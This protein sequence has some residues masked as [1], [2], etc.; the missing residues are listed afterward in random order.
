ME[1]DTGHLSYNKVYFPKSHATLGLPMTQTASQASEPAHHL[2]D[3]LAH[4]IATLLAPMFLL[5]TGGDIALAHLAALETL[6]SYR[7]RNH[8]D[9]IAV[10]QIVG[11]GLAALGSVSR[12]MEDDLSVSMVLRL[13]GNAVALNRTVEHARRALGTNRPEPPPAIEPVDL[14]TEAAVLSSVADTQQRVR[15]AK[16]HLRTPDPVPPSEPGN[17]ALT[18]QQRQAA[19]ASAMSDVANEFT[20]GLSNL[21]PVERKLASLRAAALSS[22][23][24]QLLS[25]EVP[26]RP[27]PGDLA[28]LMRP[29]RG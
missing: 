21:P 1:K 12:S 11:C 2:A 3:V 6:N 9:L 29:T 13:R 25:G 10:A 15:E 23:A 4:L 14:Q 20:A 7:A 19:W 18:D 16:A 5:A 27:R 28:A 24:N 22:C 26:S 8:I 17:P